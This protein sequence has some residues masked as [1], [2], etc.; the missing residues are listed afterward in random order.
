MRVHS[1]AGTDALMAQTLSPVRPRAR[2]RRR[3]CRGC[4]RDRALVGSAAR[5]AIVPSG[6][7]G[8]GS[9]RY[10]ATSF[11]MVD[12]NASAARIARPANVSSSSSSSRITAATAPPMRTPPAYTSTPC[13]DARAVIGSGGIPWIRA[14]SAAASLCHVHQIP[15]EGFLEIRPCC[16]TST[17]V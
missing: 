16:P 4:G 7:S 17:F 11:W 5:M 3:R 10:S 1:D 2:P 15:A 14:A 6:P 13:P 8:H 12:S 9:V